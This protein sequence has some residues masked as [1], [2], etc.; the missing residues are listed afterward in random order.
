MSKLAS[1]T[2][3]HPRISIDDIK[4]IKNSDWDER[5][6]HNIESGKADKGYVSSELKHLNDK[7]K[8]VYRDV[9]MMKGG[10][11]KCLNEKE[12]VH[13]QGNIRENTQA[14][15]KTYET[16]DQS[17][18]AAYKNY[19]KVISAMLLFFITT[20]AA[21]IWFIA[22]MSSD[23]DNN[24]AKVNK[25]EKEIKD[26]KKVREKEKEEEENIKSIIRE[27]IIEASDVSSHK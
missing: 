6:I 3:T 8:S 1:K 22:Q 27:A 4:P 12:L 10:T 17:I 19:V 26:E 15:R 11:H 21:G 13:M 23:V 14:I 2:G 18:K 5:R 7:Y 9:S 24:K 25:I 20:G 16:Y